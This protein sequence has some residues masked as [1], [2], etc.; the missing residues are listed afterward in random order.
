MDLKKKAMFM[1]AVLAAGTMMMTGCTG[2]SG[3]PA[4]FSEN[5]FFRSGGVSD[6]VAGSA[7][8]NAGAV[9]EG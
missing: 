4:A 1:L 9:S 5:G 3:Q 2:N 8:R 7:F 6:R